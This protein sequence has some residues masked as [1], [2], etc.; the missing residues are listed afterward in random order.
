[1][2]LLTGHKSAVEGDTPQLV[3]NIPLLMTPKYYLPYS[4]ESGT[5][6][7]PEPDKVTLLL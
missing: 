6:T 3:K 2:F 1:M 7:Y 4:P 5:G